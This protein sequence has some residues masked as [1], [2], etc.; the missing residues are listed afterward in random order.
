MNLPD[1][2]TTQDSIAAGK[3]GETMVAFQKVVSD[4]IT[5]AIGNKGSSATVSMSGKAG[6]DVMHTLQD[7]RSKG[8]KVTQSGTDWTVTW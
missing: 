4:A 1:A 6:A 3:S 7:L 8:Y 2:R 5:T